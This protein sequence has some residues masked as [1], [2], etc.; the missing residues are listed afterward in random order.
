MIVAPMCE[1]AKRSLD[2]SFR[3]GPRIKYG[4]RKRQLEA[5]KLPLVQNARQRL[6]RRATR[7]HV[8]EAGHALAESALRVANEI[9]CGEPAGCASDETRV[10]RVAF[11]ARFGESAAQRGNRFGARRAFAKIV[12]CKAP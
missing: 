2:Q 12:Q 5:P 10:E 4:R 3:I 9:R 6:A 7:A 1:G 11:N 8:L